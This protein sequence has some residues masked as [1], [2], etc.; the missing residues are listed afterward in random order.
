[1]LKYKDTTI[2]AGTQPPDGCAVAEDRDPPAHT[3]AVA[4]TRE[5]TEIL[6]GCGKSP[7]V[8]VK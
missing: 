8:A 4:Q 2:V 5:V 1:M 3:I 7:G 6:Q